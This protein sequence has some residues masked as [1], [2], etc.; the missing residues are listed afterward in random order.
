MT[1]T[2]NPGEKKLSVGGGKLTLKPR[3]ETGVVRQSFS[4]GRSKQV[5]VETVKR[6]AIPGA[7]A[8]PEPVVEK[9]AAASQPRALLSL[10]LPNPPRRKRRSRPASC[11][12]R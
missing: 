6:R 4:H 10:P 7:T 2:K 8:K 12:A 1:E 9:K 11:C 3:T 5:V